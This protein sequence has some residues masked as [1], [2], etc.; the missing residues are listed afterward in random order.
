VRNGARSTEELFFFPFFHSHTLVALGLGCVWFPFTGIGRLG[1][2]RV[3]LVARSNW[4]GTGSIKLDPRLVGSVG[5]LVPTRI[6][7]MQVGL[8]PP[9]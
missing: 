2:L 5:G 6:E 3:C 1:R 8:V 4:I 7:M 9:K